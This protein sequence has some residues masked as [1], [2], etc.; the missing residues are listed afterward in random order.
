MIIDSNES[1]PGP[2]YLERPDDVYQIFG[3][4]T[5]HDISERI[6][7]E[8]FVRMMGLGMHL[9]SPPEESLFEVEVREEGVDYDG[10]G[11]IHYSIRFKET[12]GPYTLEAL[13]V[14]PRD[15][16]EIEDWESNLEDEDDLVG[17]MI[18]DV[19]RDWERKV[20]LSG[21][22]PYQV[23]DGKDSLGVDPVE[24]FTDTLYETLDLS[25]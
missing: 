23:P 11:E 20:I 9:Q 3:E 19:E 5:A 17:D 1:S 25:R 8:L 22:V 18:E 7:G 4:D 13:G 24:V 14:D 12:V 15:A 2:S 21:E 16:L 6:R 10:Q